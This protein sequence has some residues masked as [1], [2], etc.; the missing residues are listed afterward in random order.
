MKATLSDQEK[1]NRRENWVELGRQAL[2]TLNTI[3]LDKDADAIA[4]VQAAKAIC[5]LSDEGIKL[6]GNVD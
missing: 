1:H 4:R 3:M 6:Y 2:K 5:A